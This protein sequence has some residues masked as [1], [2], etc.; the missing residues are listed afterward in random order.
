MGDR[1]VELIPWI[2]GGILLGGALSLLSYI[3]SRLLER[4][5]R[6]PGY[7]YEMSPVEYAYARQTQGPPPLVRLAFF[8]IL[9]LF[10]AGFIADIAMRS[11]EMPEP[12]YTLV[13]TALT[14]AVALKGRV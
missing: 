5:A 10:V 13:T 9:A 4:R 14:L 12:M 8:V 7:R 2:G 11:W 1:I 6:E 3:T